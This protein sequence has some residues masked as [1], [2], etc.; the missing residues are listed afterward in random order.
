MLRNHFRYAQFDAQYIF[1]IKIILDMEYTL[2]TAKNTDF[3]VRT[4][5][6]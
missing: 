3:K 5:E 6:K 1:Y 2:S 4:K